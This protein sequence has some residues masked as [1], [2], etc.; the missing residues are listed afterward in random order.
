M[1]KLFAAVLLLASACLSAGCQNSLQAGINISKGQSEKFSS[2]EID[3]AIDCVIAE[4]NEN[5]KGNTMTD[6]WYDEEKSNTLGRNYSAYGENN[7]IILLSN[8]KSGGSDVC[9]GFDPNQTYSD[10]NWIL[11][12]D[13]KDDAWKVKTSGY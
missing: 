3:S 12:R 9:G 1:I 10:F 8:I 13:S 5:F 7:V 6:I 4:F 11:V 2:E